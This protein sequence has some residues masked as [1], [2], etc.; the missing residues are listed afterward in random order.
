[1][2]ALKSC[3]PATRCPDRW[4]AVLRH[5]RGTHGIRL[6]VRTCRTCG[7]FHVQVENKIM[8]VRTA[9]K[10]AGWKWVTLTWKRDDSLVFFDEMAPYPHPKVTMTYIR[11]WALIR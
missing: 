2:V 5:E 4:S 6:Q 3:V 9:A 11:S 8:A 10:K 7:T 1:V